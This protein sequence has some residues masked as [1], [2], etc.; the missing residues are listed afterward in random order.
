M[1]GKKMSITIYQEVRLLAKEEWQRALRA[2]NFCH[3]GN[4]SLKLAAM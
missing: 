3:K 2:A 4:I 1:A